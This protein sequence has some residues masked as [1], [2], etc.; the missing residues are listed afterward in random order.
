MDQAEFQHWLSATSRLT[1][2]QRAEAA[3]ALSNDAD[4][5][6]SVAAVER[7]V[8]ESRICPRCGESGA[9]RKGMARGL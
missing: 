9:V 3:D 2:A 6:G 4:E 7:S 1:S 5:K 8:G